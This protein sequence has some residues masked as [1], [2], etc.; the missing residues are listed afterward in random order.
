M[1][2]NEAALIDQSF[3]SNIKIVHFVLVH[4]SFDMNYCECLGSLKLPAVKPVSTIKIS[5]CDTK[6]KNLLPS[7]LVSMSAYHEG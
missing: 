3:V 5:I 2:E 7:F 1:V 4:C 6:K